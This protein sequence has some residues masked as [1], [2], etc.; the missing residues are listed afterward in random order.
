MDQAGVRTGRG[1]SVGRQLSVALV[2]TQNLWHGGEEQAALLAE[3]LRAAGHRCR[4]LARRG[5]AFAGGMRQRGF[6][7]AE[8]AGRGRLPHAMWRIRRVLA[9]WRP[10]VLYYNDPHGITAA[11]FAAVGLSIGA[12]VAARRVDF[13]VKSVLRYHHLCDQ[14]ICVSRAVHDVCARCGLP[15]EKLS[16]VHDGVDPARMAGGDR[17]RG[18]AECGVDSNAELLLTVA[19]LTDH[20]GHRYMMDAMPAVLMSRPNTVWAIA[21]DGPLRPSLE[22]QAERLGVQHHVRFLGHRHDIPDLIAAADRMIVPSHLEGL[23]SSIADAMLAQLPVI[24]TRA[25]GIP[26]LLDARTHGESPV[27]WL[28]PARDPAALATAILT[29]FKFPRLTQQRTRD[30]WDRAHSQFTAKQMV[31]RTLTVFYETLDRWSVRRNVA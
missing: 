11:G 8:F 15:P 24:A 10:D 12:R 7:V 25:G 4:I 18:R 17:V 20:K 28:V 27:G 29:S 21:G 6:T 3:G 23:C 16:T 9:D 5:S 13:E 2:S 14:V 30:A 22:A 26:D 19:R 31:Q 1:E